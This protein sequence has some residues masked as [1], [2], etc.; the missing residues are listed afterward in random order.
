MI[1]GELT[2][3]LAVLGEDSN[4]QVSDEHQ[5]SLAAVSSAQADVVEAAVVAERDGAPGVDAVSAGPKVWVAD[6]RR[7]RRR[8]GP[9]RVG[10][11]WGAP[12]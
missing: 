11:G 10:L 7:Q 2:E 6:R 3:Q 8:L 12:A 5:H 9:G 1:E 4:L